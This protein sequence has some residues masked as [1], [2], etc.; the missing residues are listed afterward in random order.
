MSSIFKYPIQIAGLQEI[1]MPQYA[2]IMSVQTQNGYPYIW[3]LVDPS[4]PLKKVVLKVFTTGGEV[5]DYLHKHHKFI[6]TFQ[7]GEGFVGHLFQLLD[8]PS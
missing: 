2:D 8:I 5:P 4:R 3:A 7:T 1:N 6:G